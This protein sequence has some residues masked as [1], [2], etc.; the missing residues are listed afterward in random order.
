MQIKTYTLINSQKVERALNGTPRGDNTLIG[1]VANG[2]YY[3][4]NVWK[5]EGV[6][7]SEDDV[8]KLEHNIL[9][10]YDK[11][12]GAIKRGS[13]SVKTGSFYNFKAKKPFETPNV[14]FTYK[15]NGRFVD[16][17]EGEPEPGEVKA[18][19]I[20][21]ES[22]QAS[23]EEEAEEKKEKKSKRVRRT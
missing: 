19:K 22:E 21:Q 7:L 14:I 17:P 23:Q 20:L 3:E 18:L 5:R 10:E 8:A 11:L 4:G 15:I 1:G 12:G 13:D 9:A 16:V 6:E 2:A